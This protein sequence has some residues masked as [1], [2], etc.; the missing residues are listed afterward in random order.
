M[1]IAA[2][3][4]ASEGTLVTHNTDEFTRIKDLKVEDWTQE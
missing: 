1:L 3:V 2:I 4:H